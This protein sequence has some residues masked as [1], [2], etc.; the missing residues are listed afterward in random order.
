MNNKNYG[1]IMIR[2][3]DIDDVSDY[4]LVDAK[5]VEAAFKIIENCSYETIFEEL[6]K[7]KIN[8]KKLDFENV[9]SITL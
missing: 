8:Y 3:Y 2:D 6:D 9:Y 7:A 5:Q 1:L 4:L